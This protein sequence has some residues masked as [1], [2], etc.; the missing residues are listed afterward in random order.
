MTASGAQY[1]AYKE[2]KRRAI[3]EQRRAYDLQQKRHMRLSAAASKLR[4]HARKGANHQASDHNLLQRGFK[5]N[6]AGRSGKKAAAV[7]KLRDMEEKVERVHEHV[8]LRIRL[9]PV[10]V[11]NDSSIIVHA[12]QLGY[13]IDSNPKPLPLPRITMRVDYGERVAIVGFN[14]VGKSTLLKT[15]MGKLAPLNGTVT[16]GRDLRIGN[17]MQEHDSLPRDKTP[18]EHVAACCDLD[19]FK[20][21]NRIINFGLTRHQVD[22]PIGELNPGARARLLLALFSMRQ[23]NALVLDEPTNH[24]DEEA[25]AEVVATVNSYQGTVLVVSHDRQFL[26]AIQLTST[27]CLEP[28]GLRRVKSVDA[29]VDE[30]D[31]RIRKLN[32]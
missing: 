24:L 14:A 25:V 32:L 30:F 3:E 4:E 23:V 9:E 27:F 6:R 2:A 15:V 17:L 1:T 20:G 31:D 16:V 19:S 8:P 29:V 26:S 10:A 22:A 18:R 7:E 21:G 5:R 28:D 13:T 12:V 11:T